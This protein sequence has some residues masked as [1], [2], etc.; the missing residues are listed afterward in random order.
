MSFT[1]T[2]PRGCSEKDTFQE[3]SVKSRNEFVFDKLEL[4]LSFE[5]TFLESLFLVD[6][7]KNL[8]RSCKC[9]VKLL[10]KTCKN[11]IGILKNLHIFLYHQ[12]FC[13]LQQDHKEYYQQIVTEF[14]S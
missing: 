4:I 7:Y 1:K 9:L 11:L 10:Q 5:E 14:Y 8:V 13:K 6:I 12:R 2:A 3:Y